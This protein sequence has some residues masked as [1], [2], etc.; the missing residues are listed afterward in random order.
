MVVRILP[1]PERRHSG[2]QAGAGGQWA[3]NISIAARRLPPPS[4]ARKWDWA[5]ALWDEALPLPG[6]IG[7]TYFAAR[8][9]AGLASPVL[10]YHPACPHPS[11]T[12]LP[13]VVALVCNAAI[14][15][16][17][18][19]H[20]TYLRRDGGG[21]AAVEP[22][23]AT[24][25]PVAGGVVMLDAPLPGAPVVIGEGIESSAS[26]GRMLGAPAWSAISAGSLAELVLPPLPALHEVIVAADPDLPGQQAAWS[27]ARRWRAEGR[28]VQVATPDDPGADFCD[29]LLRRAAPEARHAG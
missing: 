2:P 7:M 28:Q 1:G 29:L 21:K 17:Q 26:A 16:P 3:A 13:A 4:T 19:I 6:T 5:R 20:R 24:L 22:Q 12:K 8:G 25:G 23:K 9:L 11:G 15:K 27:A 14:G 10:R 18:A